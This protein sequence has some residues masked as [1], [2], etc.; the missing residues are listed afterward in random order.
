M[1]QNMRKWLFSLS[2][3][4]ERQAMPIMTYPGLKL[5]NTNIT[6]IVKYG[7][8]QF[9]CIEALANRF[10]SSAVMTIMDL[11]VEAEAFGCPIRFSDTEVPTIYGRIVSDRDSVMALEV[12]EVG[13]GRTGAYITAAKL[14]VKHIKDRP[15]F[16]GQIGPFSLAGRLFD[17]TEIMAAI[18]LEPETIHMLLEKVTHFLVEYAKAFKQTGANGIIIAEP[19]AGLLS[20]EQCEEFSSAY[21]Q[22]I[23]EEVQDDYFMVILHNCGNTKKLVGSMINTGAMAF[24]FGNA[25]DMRDIMPQI[26]WGRIAF[27]NIDPIS[28]FRNGTVED[29]R[30][31]TWELL[32]QTFN[33]KNFV[34]SSG[35]DIP[36]GTPVE[37]I[38]GFFTKVEEFNMAMLKLLRK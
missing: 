30:A 36:P 24:H 32:E 19:A 18:L 14:A 17:M 11:S 21:V 1:Q 15:A 6:E 2:T 33:Y 37:N 31:K 38:E 34:I 9:K 13:E 20:P 28:I 16:G 7:E 27:G 29:V 12:P 26:P 4:V 3:S 10:P 23:V 22:R 25:V 5:A 8:A 35:C